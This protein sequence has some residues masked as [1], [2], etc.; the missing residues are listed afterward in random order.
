MA[1]NLQ[2]YSYGTLNNI[3]LWCASAVA[4]IGMQWHDAALTDAGTTGP[5]GVV[6]VMSQGVTR[7][8]I[9]YEGS[10]AYNNY[11]IGALARLFDLAALNGRADLVTQLAPDVQ[12]MLL[13]PML[14]RFDD[15]TLPRPSDTRLPVPPVDKGSHFSMYRHVPTAF[16]VQAAG[17]IR[18]WATLLDPPP[19]GAP[20]PVLPAAQS[21]DAEDTRM[22][23]LRSGD[24]QLFVHY[25][26]K[27]V[28]HAQEEALNYELVQGIT[29]ITRDAGTSASYSSPQHLEYFSRGVGN[30]VPLIDGM[31]QEHWAAG[32]VGS[33][34]PAGGT[35]VLRQPGYRH[36]ASAERS[37]K[38]AAGS[39]TET[40]RVVI[41]GTPATARRIG[42]VFNTDCS[43]VLSDPR[44]GVFKASA[45]PEGSPGFQHW[46]QV[47][48]ARA[49]A[50]WSA[51]LDCPGKSYDLT[52]TGPGAH[53]VYRATAPSTPLPATRTALYVETQGTDA[54]FTTRITPRP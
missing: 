6:A 37:F 53:A 42:V 7:D 51:R 23:M 18:S 16:G 26:Q 52:V 31:G 20:A 36:D 40:T 22:L 46:T 28:N 17:T 4:A 10:F 39:M 35:A 29:S 24:W 1:E 13:A 27:T 15:G 9:W 21:I 14:F 50:T 8:G 33:F 43:V 44:A 32:E 11:V 54:S 45:A 49:Q 2:T 38:L 30:N 5:K 41:A 19:A 47:T 25:G 34:D 3:N 12:R 48:Q